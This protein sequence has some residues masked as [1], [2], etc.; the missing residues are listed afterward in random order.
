VSVVF[1]KN[2]NVSEQNDFV[3][4]GVMLENKKRIYIIGIVGVPACYGGFESLVDNL[5]DYTPAD[6]DYAIKLIDGNIG[7]T[8][9]RISLPHFL[10]MF[11]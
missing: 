2:R 9:K 7:V 5:L 3:N 8:D 6:S 10:A 4:G 11:L 1:P